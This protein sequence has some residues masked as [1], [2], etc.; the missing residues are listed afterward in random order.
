MLSKLL[1][2]LAVVLGYGVLFMPVG[3]DGSPFDSVGARV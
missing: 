1:T 3:P 2:V